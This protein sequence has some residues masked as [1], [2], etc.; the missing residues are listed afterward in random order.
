MSRMFWFSFGKA[1]AFNVADSAIVSPLGAGI[2]A[3]G[4]SLSTDFTSSEE[5]DPSP[6][7]L[8]NILAA[9]CPKLKS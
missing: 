5:I 8:A 7:K 4:F 3:R 9:M 6:T 1:S 2:V